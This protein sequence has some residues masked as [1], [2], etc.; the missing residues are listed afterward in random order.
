[1]CDCSTDAN[2]TIGEV[3]YT[4]GVI[5]GGKATNGGGVYVGNSTFTMSGG[6]IAGNTATRNGGGVCVDDGTFT[7]QAA[8]DGTAPTISGNSAGNRGGGVYVDH[9]QSTMSGST[10]TGN[11][12]SWDGGG[13]YANYGT[14]D[15]SD[16]T[17]TGNFATTYGGGVYVNR[18]TFTMSNSVAISGNTVSQDGGG[19]YAYYGTLTMSDAAA[20]SNNT[21]NYYGGGVYAYNTA[22]TMQAEEGSSTAP[23]ISGNT[24][25]WGGGVHVSDGT[26]KMSAGEISGNIAKDGGCLCGGVYV[27]NGAKFEMSGTAIISDNKVTGTNGDGGG[28]YVIGNGTTFTMSGGTISNNTATRNGGGVY[29]DGGTFT[30]SGG[31]ISNNTATSYG[32]GV[33]VT[34]GTFTMSDGYLGDAIEKSISGNISIEGGYLSDEVDKSYVADGYTVVEITAD[35]GDENY[36]EGFPNAVKHGHDGKI[37]T[38]LTAAGGA[39]SGGNY[40]L[41]G[42]L[43]ADLTVSGAV[44]LCLNGYVLTGSGGGSVITVSDGAEFTLCDCSTAQNLP[45]AIA[46]RTQTTPSVKL[47][48]RRASSRAA[49]QPTAAVCM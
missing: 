40:Y 20:I 9:T 36:K 47:H 22:F 16:S 32:G 10:I 3:T 21:A 38:K 15:M 37:F 41:S 46:R 43:N 31:E 45:C 7:M 34:G 27:G 5:T 44:T 25:F 24:S 14:F 11:S 23:T 39:L 49:K 13:V 1:M 48:I 12:A 35:S 19:V 29:V 28:V 26:F 42:D 8:A 6:T 30:M 2:N 33:F 4:T 18:A 17:I